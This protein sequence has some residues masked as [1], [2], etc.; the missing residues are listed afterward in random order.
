MVRHVDSRSNQIFA[1]LYL[2]HE[3]LVALG[4]VLVNDEVA[5]IEEASDV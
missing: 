5:Y 2:M 1:S 4:V 3:K